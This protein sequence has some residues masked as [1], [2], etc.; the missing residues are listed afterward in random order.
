MTVEGHSD[1]PVAESFSIHNI[2]PLPPPQSPAMYYYTTMA[3]LPFGTPEARRT[4]GAL[5]AADTGVM[6]DSFFYPSILFVQVCFLRACV[7]ALVVHP[8]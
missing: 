1:K 6:H 7:W 2:H 8:S 3:G 4:P 5:F